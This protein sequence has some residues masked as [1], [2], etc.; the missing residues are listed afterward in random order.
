MCVDEHLSMDE[1]INVRKALNLPCAHVHVPSLNLHPP[2]DGVVVLPIHA[3]KRYVISSGDMYTMSYQQ[4]KENG[5]WSE[6]H[7]WFDLL[8]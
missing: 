4:Q 2:V 3:T 1:K 7:I 8:E 5:D 6:M